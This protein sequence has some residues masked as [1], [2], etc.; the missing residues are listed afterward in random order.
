LGVKLEKNIRVLRPAIAV[1][2][3]KI[4]FKSL[5]YLPGVMRT[6]HSCHFS[7]RSC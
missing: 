5:L 6:F 4:F 2:T 7:Y 1:R 3:I